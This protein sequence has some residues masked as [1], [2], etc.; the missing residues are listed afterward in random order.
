M[1]I[2]HTFPDAAAARAAGKLLNL[3]SPAEIAAAIE[4]LV[5]LLD[6]LGGDPDDE[7][8]DAEDAFELSPAA[9]LNSA[10]AGCRIS[11]PGGVIT[12]EDEPDMWGVAGGD[13]PGC[14]ISDADTAIDDGPCD[15]EVEDHEPDAVAFPSYGMN[16]SQQ[17][18]WEPSNDV[19]ARKPHR[20]RIRATRCET[21]PRGYFGMVGR[22]YRL[23]DPVGGC[24]TAGELTKL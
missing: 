6:A 9:R 21:S 1:G 8:I 23:S 16:Q 13:G 7:E 5:D 15:T 19:R 4:V 10:G 12:S 24:G 22:E 2:Q 14:P 17:L 20:D 18:P 11:D 3:H